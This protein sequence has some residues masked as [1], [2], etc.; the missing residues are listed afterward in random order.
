MSLR[1]TL[2]IS[3]PLR[4]LLAAAL[5]LT[6]LA[7]STEL[8]AGD[9]AT[10]SAQA[11]LS[12]PK[13]LR[14]KEPVPG[15][16]VVVLQD[17]ADV[18]AVAGEQARSLGFAA[19]PA[20]LFQHALR[21]Y[22]LRGP[23]SA[24]RAIAD[25]PRVKYVEENGVVRARDVQTGVVWGLDRVDQRTLPLDGS[26]THHVAGA[27][28]TVYVIDTGIRIT[29]AEFGGRA[30]HAFTAVNDGNGA[31]DCDGHG[32]HVAGTV[33]G[34][35]YG[36]AKAANLRAVRV[37][38]CLGNGSFAQVIAGVDWVTANRVLPAVGEHEPGRAR[39]AGGGRRGDRLRQR[40]RGLR[41]R[42][43]E[44]RGGRVRV[45]AGPDAEGAHRGRQH[46]HRRA[47]LVLQLRHLRG[48]VRPG[49]RRHQR[50]ERQ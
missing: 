5:G 29:H 25:D 38:D 36:V 15:E 30:T 14:V 9:V 33:G 2:E 18:Q 6:L 42:G 12:S 3:M 40:G 45:L 48:P 41:G 17:G 22:V 24:A 19:P 27:G 49:R 20:T 7:C 1:P 11:A 23:E 35:T 39:L 34:A 47:R 16:Y 32:T 8:P 26:Y 43:G 13:L 10:A 31:N 37:L 4:P 28:V 44:R 21:G 46:R 50:L